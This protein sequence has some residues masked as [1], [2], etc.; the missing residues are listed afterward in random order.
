MTTEPDPRLPLPGFVRR[1]HSISR[2]LTLLFVGFTMLLLLFAASYLYWGLSES[3][4]RQD[5]AL[6]MGKFQVLSVLLREHPEKTEA[7][8]SEIE[9]EAAAN[10]LLRYYLRVLDDRGR[11]LLETTDMAG[12]LPVQAFPV[13]AAGVAAPLILERFFQINKSRDQT[14]EGAGLGLAIVQS[15]MRLHRGTAEVSSTVG[16]GT[17]FTLCFPAA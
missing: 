9:H 11:V 16:Q 13:S 3:L 10:E 4:A 14:A 5:R 7:L 6:V 12:F 1:A 8:A 15:I 17:T 2:R